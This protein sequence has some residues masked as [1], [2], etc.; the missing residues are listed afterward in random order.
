MSDRPGPDQEP[1]ISYAER[2][3]VLAILRAHTAEGRLTLDEFTERAEAV[4]AARTSSD[5]MPLTAD[6]PPAE[7]RRRPATRWTMAIMGRSDRKGRWRVTDGTNAVAV[8]GECRL[9][10]RG[11]E[12]DGKTVTIRA[13]AVMG[14]VE[15]I[16]PEGIEVELTGLPIM[17]SNSLKV[18]EVS[19]VPG[20]PLVRV[21]ALALMG[22]VTVRTPRTGRADP[23]IR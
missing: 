12:F 3:Q 5:L 1:R 2:D 22:D 23:Y 21:R 7:T 20:S 19:T 10:L 17:G 16:V 8:M 4:V 6:L 15:I 18:G 9:D 13:M 14:S 11:A